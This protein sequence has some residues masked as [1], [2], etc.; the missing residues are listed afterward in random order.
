MRVVS[1]GVLGVCQTGLEE[2]EDQEILKWRH[3][4]MPPTPWASSYQTRK[5]VSCSA[6]QR[7]AEYFQFL[8]CPPQIFAQ[9]AR[10]VELALETRKSISRGNS[11]YLTRTWQEV[12][13]FPPIRGIARATLCKTWSWTSRAHNSADNRLASVIARHCFCTISVIYSTSYC[14]TNGFITVDMISA[15][16]AIWFCEQIDFNY[17]HVPNKS[18][19]L[20]VN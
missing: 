20:S 19:Q 7:A 10:F 13:T 3:T 6:K 18:Y 9:D 1:G 4:S 15:F 8:I 5:H 16:T 2:R 12:F 14:A 17:A 11:N